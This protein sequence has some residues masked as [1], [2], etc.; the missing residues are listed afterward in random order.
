[1]EKATKGFTV[2]SESLVGEGQGKKSAVFVAR[3][4]KAHR[5]PVEIGQDDG[6]RVEILSGLSPGDHVILRP[7]GEL[8]E[9]AP[10]EAE[11]PV[12]KTAEK[13]GGKD[14]RALAKQ[15]GRD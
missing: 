5:V 3:D 2:P 9:G 7:P 10:V 15:A 6:V 4:G 8:A 1:V 11:L 13:R 12:E 14:S